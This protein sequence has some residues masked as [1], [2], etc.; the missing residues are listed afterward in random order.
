MAD[1]TA[2][3]FDSPEELQEKV[4]QLAELVKGSSRIVVHT[5][6]GISTSAG[7]PDFRGPEGVWTLRAKGLKAKSR[8]GSY[9]PTLT[10][11]MIVGMLE[12]GRLYHLVSQ[13]TDG[14]HIRS[15]IPTDK[16]SELHGNT[17]MEKCSK[18][19]HRFIRSF[20]TRTA[21]KVHD[22]LTGRKCERCGGALK[23]TIVNF[24]E[25]L[26]SEQLSKAHE[27]SQGCHTNRDD[28]RMV[29]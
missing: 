28:A 3:M 1:D 2:E 20:R 8:P 22:H 17:N 15:G 16:I 13:N 9:S 29:E 14:L 26:P 19:G 18:C 27:V 6:A 7:I 24:G 23:D 12:S 25:S 5:G 4:S 10:H 21:A 11:M